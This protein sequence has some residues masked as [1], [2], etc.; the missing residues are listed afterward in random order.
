MRIEERKVKNI[1][2]KRDFFS[3]IKF[4]YQDGQLISVVQSSK[5]LFYG[6]LCS[7]GSTFLCTAGARARS[8]IF[9]HGDGSNEVSHAPGRVR[10]VCF[11]PHTGRQTGRIDITNIQLGKKRIQPSIKCME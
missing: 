7:E 3:W 6:G 1:S 8:E 4:I 5:Q 9:F 2:A 10:E 11:I